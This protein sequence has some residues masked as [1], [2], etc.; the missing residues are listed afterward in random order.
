MML[1]CEAS[2]WV[3]L[4]LGNAGGS[5]TSTSDQCTVLRLLNRGGNVSNLVANHDFLGVAVLRNQ[6]G[7]VGSELTL[8]DIIQRT[9]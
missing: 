2:R 3:W 7:F 4:K 8:H 6:P 1:P 9:L 5:G